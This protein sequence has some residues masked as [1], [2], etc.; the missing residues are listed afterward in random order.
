MVE[1]YFLNAE[2]SGKI[3]VEVSIPLGSIKTIIRQYREGRLQPRKVGRPPCAS[4]CAAFE[5][6]IREAYDGDCT[7]TIDQIREIILEKYN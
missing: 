4:M 6:T 5:V 1:R 7:L 2:T 3:A